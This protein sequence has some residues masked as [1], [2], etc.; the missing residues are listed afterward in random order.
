MGELSLSNIESLPFWV[1]A[2]VAPGILMLVILGI[3]QLGGSRKG[4]EPEPT[5][6]PLVDAKA[7]ELTRFTRDTIEQLNGI[8][9]ALRDTTPEAE[10]APGHA[11]L[12]TKG[13]PR[14]YGWSE[15]GRRRTVEPVAERNAIGDE[16][17]SRD[18][19]LSLDSAVEAMHSVTR[20]KAV[21]ELAAKIRKLTELAGRMEDERLA[22][23][24]NVLDAQPAA[25]GPEQS[26]H[27]LAFA[28]GDEQFALSIENIHGVIEAA[29]L[30]TEPSVSPK[31]RRAIKLHGALVPVIDLGA[32]L[33]GQPLEI[34][35]SSRILLLEVTRHDRLQIIGVV[36]DTAGRVLEIK[37]QDIQPPAVCDIQ[38]RNDFA[39]GTVTIDNRAITLLDIERGYSVNELFV[40]QSAERAKGPA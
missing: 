32:L 13:L 21:A 40:L 17:A 25:S 23:E 26:E 35:W 27:Y 15:E 39:F 14:P 31:V 33:S 29:Q 36:V 3:C 28:L 12:V 10:W 2:A 18:N 22:L 11:P 34:G 1:M 5:A 20:D 19:L 4:S 6:E 16:S 8:A 24:R 7:D 30:V 37:P 9:M 38:I